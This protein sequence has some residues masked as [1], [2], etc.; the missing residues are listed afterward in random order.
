MPATKSIF[1]VN[2]YSWFATICAVSIAFSGFFIYQKIQEYHGRIRIFEGNNQQYRED[3]LAMQVESVM[4]YLSWRSSVL[5]DGPVSGSQKNLVV[6]EIRNI[7]FGPSSDGNVFVM[8]SNGTVLAHPAGK[9]LEGR[10]YASGRNPA[11]LKSIIHASKRRGGGFTSYEEL[12]ADTGALDKKII[13]SSYFQPWDLVVCAEL[14]PFAVRRVFVEN[15]TNLK[16]ALICETGFIIFMCLVVTVLAIGFSYSVSKVLKKEVDLITSYLEDSVNG[17]P[18]MDMSLFRFTELKFIAI[19][20]VKMIAKI[21]YL[22][23]RIKEMAINS[24]RSSRAKSCYLANMSHE[25]RNPLNGILGMAE[26]LK[27]TNL[28]KEQKEYLLAIFASCHSLVSLVNSIRD[29][30]AGETGNIEIVKQPFNL[31]NLLT[32]VVDYEEPDAVNKNIKLSF[33]ISDE[34]PEW[35]EGDSGKIFQALT[36]L[37]ENALVFIESGSISISLSCNQ[38]DDERAELLFSVTDTGPGISEDKQDLIFD[39]AHHDISVS[40]EFASVSLGLAVC[41]ELVEAMGGKIR[42]SSEDG[43]G[44]TFSFTI[45]V[46][47]AK[48]ALAEENV[49]DI[50]V[51][52]LRRDIK[53]LLVEDDP[54][55]QKVGISFLKRAGCESVDIAFNGL[56]GVDKFRS[57][58]YDIIFMDCEMPKK[59]GYVATSEIRNLEK[60]EKRIPIIAL[61]ANALQADK[62]KCLKAGMDDHLSKPVSS[63]AI[64]AILAKYFSV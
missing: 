27:D 47:I 19:N 37:V 41:K 34:A 22:V 36:T 43:K 51:E 54:I 49:A 32:K 12:S 18:C 21:K 60:G 24:E 17:S 61:T 4:K 31:K 35:V 40:S 45:P 9:L 10:K 56:Q 7:K 26:L 29:F 6:N 64:A 46:L 16:I 8:S 13:Y 28:D 59:D 14:D 53:V 52:T 30:S 25:I 1:K 44:A 58:N 15:K 5:K 57:G 23:A 39:F 55:N 2:L 38:R 3:I 50:F 62:E 63:E 20:A 11:I 33:N 42:I 48:G